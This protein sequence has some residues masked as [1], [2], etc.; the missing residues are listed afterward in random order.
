MERE[1][2]AMHLNLPETPLWR[3]FIDQITLRP[4]A[5]GMELHMTPLH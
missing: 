5:P 2:F 3:G 1:V 4:G